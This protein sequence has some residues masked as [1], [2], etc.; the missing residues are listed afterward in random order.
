MPKITLRGFIDIPAAD[1]DA[2]RRE[3]PHHVQLTLAEEGCMSFRV[4]PDAQVSGRFHVVEKFVSEAAFERH[5]AR[6]QD[7]RWG[8]ITRR[9]TRHYDVIRQA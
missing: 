9:A 5:Q 2:A 4:M 7:S 8:K 3:L 6:L 1:L